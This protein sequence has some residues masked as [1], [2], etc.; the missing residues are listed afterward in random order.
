M[1][2]IIPLFVAI[3]L[4]ACGNVDNSNVDNT[5]NYSGEGSLARRIIDENT[6]IDFDMKEL[7]EETVITAHSKTRLSSPKHMEASAEAK[8]ATYR[9]YSNIKIENNQLI[10][11]AKSGKELNMSEKVFNAY[12]DNIDELNRF[13]REAIERGDSIVIPEIT[14]EYLNSLLQ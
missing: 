7:T 1:S 14:D 5:V 3:I 10:Q 11:T 9:F 13:A 4:S 8:A 12:M 6:F 2:K